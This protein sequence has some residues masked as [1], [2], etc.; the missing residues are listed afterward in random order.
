V[1]RTTGCSR[2]FKLARKLSFV[3]KNGLVRSEADPELKSIPKCVLLS[4]LYSRP[5]R[6]LH[7]L[8]EL[9]VRVLSSTT[10]HGTSDIQNWA[11]QSV[12]NLKKDQL[13]SYF[14]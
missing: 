8:I 13:T 9:L 10:R 12:S 3:P 11:F 2:R 5:D 4:R 14:V 1:L 6:H 7:V